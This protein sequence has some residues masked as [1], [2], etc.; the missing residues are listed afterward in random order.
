MSA[1]LAQATLVLTPSD[2]ISCYIYPEVKQI[3]KRL[4][5]TLVLFAC[6][7]GNAQDLSNWVEVKGG[8]WSPTKEVLNQI[9]NQIEPQALLEAKKRSRILIGL[10]KYTFQYQGQIDGNQKMVKIHAYCQ[11]R[12]GFDPSQ[13][14]LLVLDGGICYLNALYDVDSNSFKY[15][16][17]NGEG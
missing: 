17:F 13:H 9:Q 1:G 10:E 16:F 2:G 11:V 8:E 12:P 14:W 4:F 5:V 6:I 7:V 15:L 3:M